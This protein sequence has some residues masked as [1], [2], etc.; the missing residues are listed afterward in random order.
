[1]GRD[2]A[3]PKCRCQ[4]KISIFKKKN[5]DILRA[6]Y[7]GVRATLP[8]GMLYSTK[9][10]GSYF[11]YQGAYSVRIAKQVRIARML[12]LKADRVVRVRYS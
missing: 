7:A 11:L 9:A 6:S 3:I 1:M 5:N 2:I 8:P 10:D 4:A 12:I